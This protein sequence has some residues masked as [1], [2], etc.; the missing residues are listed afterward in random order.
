MDPTENTTCIVDEACLPRP[1]LSNV[2]RLSGYVFTGPLPS[3][4]LFIV[5]YTCVAGMRLPIRC[6]ATDIRVTILS[7]IYL[8]FCLYLNNNRDR[9]M[10]A[11][12]VI[13]TD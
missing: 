4:G 3:N 7:F 1:F 11:D 10:A 5:A 8:D 9:K 12:L 6:L 2:T 13:Q